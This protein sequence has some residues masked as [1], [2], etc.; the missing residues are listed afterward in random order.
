MKYKWL[1]AL[2]VV[3][4]MGMSLFGCAPKGGFDPD[5]T[6]GN[7]SAVNPG[8]TAYV[9]KEEP[10]DKLVTNVYMQT[11]EGMT[12]Q[13]SY[14]AFA[15]DS[16]IETKWQ[17][18]S[19]GKDGQVSVT[20]LFSEPT[21]IGSIHYAA[22]N[23]P[24]RVYYEYS[25]DGKSWA[26]LTGS[27]TDHV[28]KAEGQVAKF[29][30][31]TAS[32]LSAIS[33][34]YRFEISEMEFYTTDAVS[35]VS[36]SPK[37]A[38]KAAV[39]NNQKAVSV[40]ENQQITFNF[41]SQRAIYKMRVRAK[42]GAMPV[43][44]IVSYKENN[45][46]KQLQ[47]IKDLKTVDGNQ[48]FEFDLIYTQEISVK[49]GG[50]FDLLSVDFYQ[51]DTHSSSWAASDG[52]GRTV[53]S[54]D[55][56]SYGAR[57]NKYVGIFYF[58]WNYGAKYND[59]PRDISKLEKQYPDLLETGEGLGQIY[60]WHH[61]GESVYG[62]Y[63]QNDEWVVR[64]D[65]QMLA[66]A[67]VDTLIFDNTNAAV[68]TLDSLTYTKQV[69]ALMDICLDIRAHGGK[70]PQFM[71]FMANSSLENA[72]AVMNYWWDRMYS[73]GKYSDLWFRWDNGKPMVMINSAALTAEQSEFFETRQPHG[74]GFAS[75]L[76]D[77]WNWM[78]T[79][80]QPVFTTAYDPYEEMSISTAQNMVIDPD[81]EPNRKD[82][83]YVAPFSEGRCRGRD[84]SNGTVAD[85]ESMDEAIALGANFN[86]QIGRALEIDPRFTFITGWNEWIMQRL[87]N[88]WGMSQP[89]MFVD[90][91]NTRYNRDIMPMKG[92]YGDATY[93]QM[94][95]FIR[96]YKGVPETPLNSG[97]KTIGMHDFADW[98]DVSNRY[99]D[100]IGD[101]T[102]RDYLGFN[103]KDRYKNDSGR[104]DIIQCKVTYDENN[105]YFYAKT[106]EDITSYKDP[107]WMR[108]FIKTKGA[109][110]GGYD[111]VVNREAPTAKK[112]TLEK[113]N[114]TGWSWTKAGNVDYMVSGRE[115]QIFIPREMLGL[116]G[117]VNF[118]FKWHDNMQD[119][120]NTDD[121]MTCG[122]AAPT[123]RFNYVFRTTAWKK[124][125]PNIM[126]GSGRT[127]L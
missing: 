92:G 88:W 1:C 22:E 118:E 102:H 47:E 7:R 14:A 108:L 119:Q 48:Y 29:V 46:V 79:Y 55:S 12:E 103:L 45:T 67:G 66:D 13:G 100:D 73:V 16:H 87:N 3:V 18:T 20:F 26:E 127:N 19:V 61:W 15:V 41:G 96:Q 49:F 125:D 34:G 101:V 86:E 120:G 39:P 36:V 6:K 53:A 95:N 68:G 4:T 37:T 106:K 112:C 109:G 42:D 76:P 70:T 50:A 33:N 28:F 84:F 124:Q 32:E 82:Y 35:V 78:T 8:F 65:M 58:L 63:N 117:E 44:M 43:S 27:E 85:D 122:D 107:A 25:K 38:A 80:P 104:N 64:K 57:Q 83:A 59:G 77:T 40:A 123:G 74:S 24:G 111:F 97:G 52:Y 105:V 72:S 11:P 62:Y 5:V 21:S 98:L 116:T 75:S 51:W 9:S 113:S 60:D 121:F 10:A 23:Y 71:F 56:V 94:V 30:K 54:N 91:Y 99:Y 69:E 89:N 2:A 81:S 115:I 31:A 93:Y 17:S 90:Q 110:W 126:P 114:G